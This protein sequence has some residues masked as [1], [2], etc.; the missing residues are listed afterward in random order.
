MKK[1][2][3]FAVALVASALA[4]T[5]CNVKI[6]SP[7]VGWWSAPTVMIDE[8]LQE[9]MGRND[10]NFIDNGQFQQNEYFNGTFDGYYAMG[11]WSVKDNKVTIRKNT[12]GTIKN[13][14][15]IPD[16][17]FKPYEQQFTWRIEGHYLYLVDEEGNE[18]SFRDGKP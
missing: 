17:N 12:Y 18:Y 11:K 7:L 2:F 15:F 14:N 9:R 6:D 5:S 8:N 4:F 10:L 16:S 1:F 3:S 13:N